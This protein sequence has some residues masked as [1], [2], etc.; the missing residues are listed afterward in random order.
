MSPPDYLCF[1]P[2][3]DVPKS[4]KITFFEQVQNGRFTAKSGHYGVGVR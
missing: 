2:K 3:A 1:W 4:V